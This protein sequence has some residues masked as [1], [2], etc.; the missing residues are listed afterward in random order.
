MIIVTNNDDN[1]YHLLCSNY[2][3]ST[4]VVS[5]LCKGYFHLHITEEKLKLRRLNNLV[6]FPKLLKWMG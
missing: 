3:L 6:K 4:Y 1:R 2:V 5:Y